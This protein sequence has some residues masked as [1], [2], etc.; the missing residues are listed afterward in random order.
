MIF[1]GCEI[2]MDSA[3]KEF[4]ACHPLLYTAL[5]MLFFVESVFYIVLIFEFGISLCVNIIMVI[6]LAR[7]PG[8]SYDEWSVFN[9]FFCGGVA[10]M[11]TRQYI[12]IMTW[13]V[14]QQVFYFCVLCLFFQCFQICADGV[15]SSPLMEQYS[16]SE[17]EAQGSICLRTRCI[18]CKCY[19][20]TWVLVSA[21]ILW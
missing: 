7:M 18:V 19:M 16:D 12:R 17:M 2:G 9:K 1:C 15:A 5:V 11:R 3:V 13:S 21:L 8:G 6:I 4:G 20:R 14:V 10:F